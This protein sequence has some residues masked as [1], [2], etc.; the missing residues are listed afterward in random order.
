MA[1]YFNIN[2]TRWC[3]SYTIVKLRLKIFILLLK[4]I[5]WKQLKHNTC[6]IWFLI[7]CTFNFGFSRTMLLCFYV[8]TDSLT[9]FAF[10]LNQ[11]SDFTSSFHTSC[12]N[13]YF[14]LNTAQPANYW[15]NVIAMD[16]YNRSEARMA[17]LILNKYE[18][19]FYYAT[20]VFLNI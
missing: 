19:H 4:D 5:Y 15:C 13:N 2:T 8:T 20:L 10:Y 12:D 18:E 9:Y 17:C 7:Y 1:L 11:L 3:R 16:Y 14:R 6:I